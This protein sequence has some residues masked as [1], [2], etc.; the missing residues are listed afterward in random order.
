MSLLGRLQTHGFI[1]D[2]KMKKSLVAAGVV[3]ALGIV[4]TGGAGTQERNSKR[5]SP[6]W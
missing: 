6:R 4:W 3:V 1:M 2:I 5:I